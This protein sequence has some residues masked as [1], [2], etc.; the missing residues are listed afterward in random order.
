M[1]SDQ[2]LLEQNG[3]LKVQLKSLASL[4]CNHC[5]LCRILEQ[6]TPYALQNNVRE[7]DATLMAAKKRLQIMEKVFKR[8][9]FTRYEQYSIFSDILKDVDV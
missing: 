6:A 8:D 1:S 3:E 9:I 5:V 7:F 4:Y 2:Q